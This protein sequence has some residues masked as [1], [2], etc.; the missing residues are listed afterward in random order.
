[1]GLV[2]SNISTIKCSPAGTLYDVAIALL[3]YKCEQ[4]YLAA[5]GYWVGCDVVAGGQHT[6]WDVW[7]MATCGTADGTKAHTGT[8]RQ[9]QFR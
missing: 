9:H 8:G 3:A 4:G 1:M 7:H 5:V 6:V 2:L